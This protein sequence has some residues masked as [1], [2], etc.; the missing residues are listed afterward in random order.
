VESGEVLAD[1]KNAVH[2]RHLQD[3]SCLDFLKNELAVNPVSAGQGTL[4]SLRL[5]AYRNKPLPSPELEYVEVDRAAVLQ[6]WQAVSGHYEKL[7]Q[8]A[9]DQMLLAC[10]QQ[11]EPE[12]L[13]RHFAEVVIHELLNAAASERLG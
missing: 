9:V 11:H 13:L 7:I 3:Q 12:S 1:I 8:T 5:P 4:L 2:P 6:D 10:S